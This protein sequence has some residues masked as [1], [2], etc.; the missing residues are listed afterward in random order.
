MNDNNFFSTSKSQHVH[1]GVIFTKVV[2]ISKQKPNQTNKTQSAKGKKKVLCWR[3]NCITLWGDDHN[4]EETFT[5]PEVPEVWN[6]GEESSSS[7]H[8]ALMMETTLRCSTAL[9]DVSDLIQRERGSKSTDR[10]VPRAYHHHTAQTAGKGGGTWAQCLRF[11]KQK[12]IL[13]NKMTFQCSRS[14][15]GL[16]CLLK[17]HLC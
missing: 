1:T 9:N 3:W 7:G 16:G 10:T 12:K 5:E 11:I 15:K 13:A 14:S 4:P 2:E 8:Q 6:D 17:F